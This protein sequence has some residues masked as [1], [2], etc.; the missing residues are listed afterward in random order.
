ML[1]S[2]SALCAH[3]LQPIKS[4]LFFQINELIIKLLIQKGRADLNFFP[5][6]RAGCPPPCR[7]SSGWLCVAA[8]ERW[9]LCSVL[10]ALLYVCSVCSIV[11]TPP[12]APDVSS[13]SLVAKQRFGAT[14]EPLFL[15]ECQFF[16]EVGKTGFLRGT[17][18][19][20][21]LELARQKRGNSLFSCCY[22]L[23]H[24]YKVSFQV[25]AVP[26]FC[27]RIHHIKY[28]PL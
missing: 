14:V 20:L 1:L 18:V 10:L 24:L 13:S 2:C 25:E 19:E 3:S 5:Q 8:E 17:G 9:A 7:S 26:L 21:A 11:V 28:Y 16:V 27:Q 15:N 4:A 22:E 6:V 23:R 12:P